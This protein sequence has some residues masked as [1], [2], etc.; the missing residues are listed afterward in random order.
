MRKMIASVASG[1]YMLFTTKKLDPRYNNSSAFQIA[2][3]SLNNAAATLFLALM[4]YT[5]YFLNGVLGLAVVATSVV[6]TGL[7]TFDGLIDPFIGY[8]VDR[9]EGRFGKF[10]PFMIGGNIL[11]AL[12]IFLMFFVCNELPEFFRIPFFVVLYIIFVFGYTFQLLVSKSGQTVMTNNPKM[13]PLVTYFDSMFVTSCYGGTALYVSYYLI[14][15]YDSFTNP[16]LFREF[17]LSVIAISAICTI[18][19]LVGI[20]KKDRKEFYGGNHSSEKI[21]VKDYFIVLKK[22]RPIRMLIMAAAINKF[23]AMVYSNITVGV[24][25]FGIMMNNYNMYGT[26]GLVTALPNLVVVTIGVMIAQRMGQKKA[27]TIFTWLAV[28]FQLLMTVVLV[29]KDLTV[30]G[31]TQFNTISIAFFTIF[32]L[33]NGSKAVSN[34]IVIPMIADCSDYEVYRSG[35][36][37]PGMMG[38]LFSLVDQVISALGTAF[39]GVVVAII[40]FRKKLPQVED[41]LSPQ[42][43]FV[44]V[45]CYCIVP[46]LG[47]MTSLF[48]MRY[49]DLDKDKMAEISKKHFHFHKK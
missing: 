9:T 18:L 7:R 37:V 25:L 49:Y 36:Y 4:E 43:R 45:L 2:L 32:I 35:L 19:A 12:S 29:Q 48:I 26:I 22:N 41:A 3:F 31:L 13:R 21:R 33:L 6:L 44:T 30:I 34:N 39:V 11:M 42:I 27:F 15:K 10:R 14:S 47:W 40:G 5:A 17:A 38:A 1:G 23:A 8:I 46:M 20:W 16:G 28:F 24:M